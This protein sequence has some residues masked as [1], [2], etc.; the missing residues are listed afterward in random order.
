VQLILACVGGFVL[1]LIALTTILVMANEASAAYRAR[2]W[3]QRDQLAA[4]NLETFRARLRND[5]WWFSEDQPTLDLLQGLAN[6]ERVDSLREKWRDAR[7]AQHATA[8]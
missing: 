7:K 8:P 5:A 4:A 6:G 2:K 3:V 1:I